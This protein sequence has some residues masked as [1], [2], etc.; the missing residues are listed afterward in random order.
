M[1]ICT[2]C[3]VHPSNRGWD[4]VFIYSVVYY[5]IYVWSKVTDRVR[6]APLTL[7]ICHQSVSP[8]WGP[9]SLLTLQSASPLPVKWF[10]AKQLAAST[11]LFYVFRGDRIKVPLLKREENS[12][13]NPCAQIWPAT[14]CSPQRSKVDPASMNYTLWGM[15]RVKGYSCM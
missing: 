9:G 6:K 8:W 12:S 7:Q 2:K 5:S 14:I 15:W 13:S 3:H 1:N 11:W 4:I 10:K